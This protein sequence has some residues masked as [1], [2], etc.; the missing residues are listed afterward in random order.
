[1]PV[2]LTAGPTPGPST[3]DKAASSLGAKAH[4]FRVK[5]YGDKMCSCKIQLYRTHS[6]KRRYSLSA[7]LMAVVPYLRPDPTEEEVVLAVF[8]YIT[9]NGLYNIGGRDKDKPERQKD[10]R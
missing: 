6:T 4:C 5:I 2:T 1:M 8:E 7:E 9:S 3:A 10:R